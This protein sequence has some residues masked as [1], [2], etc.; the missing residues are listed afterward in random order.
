MNQEKK[1]IHA[2]LAIDPG[3]TTGIGAGY[4]E[5]RPTR[6]ETLSTLYHRKAVEVTGDWLEQSAQLAQMMN[7]FVF[8]ANVENSLPLDNIHIC[9]EDFILRRRQEGGATGNLTSCWVAAG[10]VAL[11]QTD[12]GLEVVEGVM[13]IKWQQ[14]SHA[15]TLMTDARLKSY[16]LW[17][18]GSAHLRDVWRHFGLRVDGLII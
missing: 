7:R 18:V 5:L 13:P 4:V 8:T 14:P 2:V 12:Q 3:G 15:K 17:E 10:A 9:I 6:R 16:G 1:Q 11:F